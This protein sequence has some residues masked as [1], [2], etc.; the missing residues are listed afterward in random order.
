MIDIV[1]IGSQIG[2]GSVE[3]AA[4]TKPA[5]RSRT[6]EQPSRQQAGSGPV[7]DTVVLSEEAR[8]KGAELRQAEARAESGET[9]GET[10]ET[11]VERPAEKEQDQEVRLSEERKQEERDKRVKEERREEERKAELAKEEQLKEEKVERERA[12]QRI[13]ERREAEEQRKRADKERLQDLLNAQSDYV[14]VFKKQ[15][16]RNP[17]AQII[18]KK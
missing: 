1:R 12:E 11:G 4:A 8:R 2:S 18:D 10:G 17:L 16:Q 6:Q 3:R 13:K 15:E 14:G 5:D 9:S 7:N